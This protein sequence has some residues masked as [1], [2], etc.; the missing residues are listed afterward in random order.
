[1]RSEL[2][3]LADEAAPAAFHA[4]ES[5]VQRR[6]GVAERTAARGARLIRPFMP[7]QHREF[8]AQLPFVN[9]GLADKD[10]WPWATLR[11]GSPGFVSS[12]DPIT[13]VIEAAAPPGEADNLILA[14]GAKVGVVGVELP[15]RRRNRMNGTLIEATAGRLVVRVDQSFGNCP[16]YIHARAPRPRP[17]GETAARTPPRSGS[18]LAPEDIAWIGGADTFFIASR[19]G[20]LA[21][22][23]R[24]GLDVSHRGGPPGFV[25]VLAPDALVFPDYRGNNFFNTLGNIAED[26]RVGLQFLDF[27]RGGALSVAGRARVVW[28]SERLPAFP[29][30]QR[31]VEVS[32]ER[33]VRAENVIGLAFDLVERWDRYAP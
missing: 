14:P 22:D 13:L 26:G 11:A 28:D 30:A 18:R 2:T 8:F 7:D 29:A 31:L 19:T 4:G 16:Q 25:R 10:G 1:M 32:I 9:L 15:T 24:A 3:M 20:T 6:A 5:A 33:V 12:P 23:A 17:P 21:G 27:R